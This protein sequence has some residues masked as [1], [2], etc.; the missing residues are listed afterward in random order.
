M[1]IKIIVMLAVL[2]LLAYPFIPM[3]GRLRKFSVAS[4]LKYRAPHNRKNFFF[5]LLSLIESLVIILL[6]K[7]FDALTVF[8]YSIPFIG[9]LFSNAINSINTQL[10]YVLFAIKIIIVNLIAVYVYIFLKAIL[11]KLVIN[12]IYKIG[13]PVKIRLPFSKKNKRE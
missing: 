2:L 7:A 10:D 8:L 3:K 9:G 6:F 11:R 4:S 1:A 13:K 12:R 5:V